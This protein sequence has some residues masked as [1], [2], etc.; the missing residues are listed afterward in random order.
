MKAL[1]DS[2][3]ALLAAF[4]ISV[5]LGG[6]AA[7]QDNVAGNDANTTTVSLEQTEIAS[8]SHDEAI[9]R[10]AGKFL[11]RYG[12]G[13]N[14]VALDRL[15]EKLREAHLNVEVAPG[16]P[17]GEITSYIYGNHYPQD[18][19]DESDTVRLEVILTEIARQN[20]LFASLAN[21]TPENS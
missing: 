19:Y 9:E 10:S 7:A 11:L 20:N 16:G 13:F 5:G 2:S 4:A 3:K 14:T 1:L 15:V 8:L 21:T 6:A 12:E 17:A 18:S